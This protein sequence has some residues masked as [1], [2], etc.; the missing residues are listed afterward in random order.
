MIDRASKAAFHTFARSSTLKRIAS[1]YGM[2]SP[3]GFARRFIAGETVDE[4][5]TVARTMGQG[6][7]FTITLPKAWKNGILE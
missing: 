5:I 1:R 2:R 7:T 6:S 3:G 4:A